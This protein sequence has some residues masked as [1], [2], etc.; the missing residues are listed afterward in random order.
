M[1]STKRHF[2]FKIWCIIIPKRVILMLRFGFS[3]RNFFSFKNLT[4]SHHNIQLRF[5][6]LVL[7]GFKTFSPSEPKARFIYSSSNVV[8]YQ[9]C[10]LG[11]VWGLFNRKIHKFRMSPTSHVV[12][13]EEISHLG[14]CLRVCGCLPFT[15]GSKPS[16]NVL[17]VLLIFQVIYFRRMFCSWSW[18]PFRSRTTKGNDW[19]FGATLCLVCP[20]NL[21]VKEWKMVGN[22]FGVHNLY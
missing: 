1:I 22:M 11:R 5:T 3:N 6:R 17:P 9:P 2:N 4:S 10:F 15:F 18:S 20:I 13:I 21:F 16:L 8:C 14:I 12:Y 7:R 19:V